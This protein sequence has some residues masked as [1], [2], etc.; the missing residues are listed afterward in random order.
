MSG[1]GTSSSDFELGTLGRVL[2]D[3][4]SVHFT[5]IPVN[6]GSMVAGAMRFTNKDRRCCGGDSA[7]AGMTIKKCE[8][9]GRSN[10]VRTRPRS[11][12]GHDL[13]L[14]VVMREFFPEKII[15]AC[16]GGGA[17]GTSSDLAYASGGALL[18]GISPYAREGRRD[19][20][21]LQF[22]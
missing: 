18:A 8:H 4:F 3:A 9:F 20:R 6:A 2:H 7:F 19:A 17:D 5:V 21:P 10:Q 11:S 15:V 1:A 12:Q 13:F 22:T 14:K 16:L